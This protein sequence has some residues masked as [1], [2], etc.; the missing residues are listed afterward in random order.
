M[1]DDRIAAL[2]ADLAKSDWPGVDTPD[3]RRSIANSV[4]ILRAADPVTNGS[5]YSALINTSNDWRT[6]GT[7]QS[8]AAFVREHF[9]WQTTRL[10]SLADAVAGHIE[11]SSADLLD[12]GATANAWR[13][14]ACALRAPGPGSDR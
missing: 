10:A 7:P 2:I 13:E 6:G 4:A 5:A 11:V 9:G 1:T 3:R 14:Y 8:S 12:D